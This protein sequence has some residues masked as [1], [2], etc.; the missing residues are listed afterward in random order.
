MVPLIPI[1]YA[2]DGMVSG[3]RAYTPDGVMAIARSVPGAEG[4]EWQSGRAGKALYLT[5]TPRR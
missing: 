5:G 3:L 4:Y 2:W 1:L